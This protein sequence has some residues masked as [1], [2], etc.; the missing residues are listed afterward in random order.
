[1]TIV[2][3]STIGLIRRIYGHL[4]VRRRRQL[5]IL[6]MLM[7]VSSFVEAISIS[8]ILPFL[9]A[10]AT[11]ERVREID[12]LKPILAYFEINDTSELRL[13]FTLLFIGLVL[14]SGT[15]R[16]VFFWLQTRLGMAIGIDFSVQVYEKTLYQ[17]YGDLISRNSSEILAGAQKAKDLVGYII[18]PTLTFISSIFMLVAV[19]SAL[20]AIEPIVALSSILGFGAL[21]IFATTA[22]KRLLQTNSRTYATE[23]GRVNKAIQEGIGGIRDVIIDGTQATYSRLY[24]AALTK[25]QYAAAGNAILAQSP[26][27]VIEM[28]GMALLAGIT[29]VLIN[30]D[31]SFTAM[32]PTLG[33]IALGAQ[34]L[35]P[36]LQQ[37]YSAYVTIRGGVD[38]T[39]DALNL[40]DQTVSPAVL[41]ER[42]NRLTFDKTIKVDNLNFSYQS[43][44]RMILK[45]IN[46]EIKRGDRIGL[47]GA[48]GSGKSTLVDLIM[49]LLS[50]TTGAIFIDGQKLCD[51]N[52]KDWH[53]CIS[54]VPQSIFLADTTI[55]E[56]IAFGVE[57]HEIDMERVHDAAKIAKISQT[58]ESFPEGYQTHVGERGIRLS[59]GQRQRIGIARAMYKRSRV[60]I[61]DEATSALDGETESSVMSAIDEIG[62]NVTMLLIAHRLSTLRS[63]DFLIELKNGI[64]S[65]SGTYRELEARERVRM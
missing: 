45:D 40:L 59:G 41:S 2:D 63:C 34:R 64:V 60:L 58:I 48:T 9:A 11:P 33:V 27:F 62:E 50:P 51:D 10:L 20:F 19:L 29:F 26:R 38:S 52:I 53:S 32:I 21:Y 54:H 13:A 15:F 8:S 28:L 5:A 65:W 3:R 4:T 46:L 16:I 18:Q 37:A 17:P 30:R 49:G 6:G 39:M 35:L 61:L 56:N 24:R 25:M 43:A 55:A 22:S 44:S 47:I 7:V 12:A 14:L 36:V 42:P 57:R 1:M 31:V 23:L